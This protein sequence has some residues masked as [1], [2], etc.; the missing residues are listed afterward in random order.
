MALKGTLKDFSLADILQLIG[1]QRKTGV[2]SLKHGH[3]SVK[4]FFLEGNVVAADS[5]KRRLEDRL[6]AVLVKSRRLTKKQLDQALHIQRQT[7]KRLGSVLVDLKLIEPEELSEALQVQVSQMI[8]HLFRWRNGEYDFDQEEALDYDREHVIPLSA[9]SLLMEG[10]RILDEWPMIE[11]RLGPPST[12]YR[13]VASGDR[14]D[15][16]EAGST[17]AANPLEG[18]I[19]QF[20]QEPR[21]LQELVGSSVSSEFDTCKALVELMGQDRVECLEEE[22]TPEDRTAAPPPRRTPGATRDRRGLMGAILGIWVVLSLGTAFLN[23]LN[24]LALL[25]GG[26]PVSDGYMRQVS[27]TKL[28]RLDYAVQVFYLQNRGFPQNLEYLVVGGLVSLDDLRDPWGRP[29]G[30]HPT[31]AGYALQ[32]F[33]STGVEDPLLTIEEH[34]S[35]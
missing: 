18:H 13:T 35:Q 15:S 22:V 25:R 32:G 28:E 6:G 24:G 30:Y 10:A 31:A 9:E 8:Y 27:R 7:L 21:S 14:E 23:P 17:S 3:E 16:M 26:H 29:Y 11:E 4:I 20:L 12:R 19:L 1:L 33:L 2:L 34:F 5:E